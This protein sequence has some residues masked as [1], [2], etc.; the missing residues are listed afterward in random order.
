MTRNLTELFPRKIHFVTRYFANMTIRSRLIFQMSLK[1]ILIIGTLSGI[2]LLNFGPQDRAIISIPFIIIGIFTILRISVNY[3]FVEAMISI[4]SSLN[5]A[6]MVQARVGDQHIERRSMLTIGNTSV[7]GFDVEFTL[8]ESSMYVLC[9][10]TIYFN[11]QQRKICLVRRILK[12]AESI[13]QPVISSKLCTHLEERRKE[14][15]IAC[16]KFDDFNFKPE[17]WRFQ[18][19]I[20]EE[21]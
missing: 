18:R 2:L 16:Q 6:T 9:S 19:E 20:A 8:Y 11:L 3:Q 17:V 14:L 15:F 13:D 5:L 4:M 12:N 21:N 7:F 10:I 1:T